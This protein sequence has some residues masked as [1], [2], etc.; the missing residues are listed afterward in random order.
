VYT[1]NIKTLKILFLLYHKI[2]LQYI[3][4]F[5]IAQGSDSNNRVKRQPVPSVSDF[6]LGQVSNYIN[7]YQLDLFPRL[8]A[9]TG[10]FFRLLSH[11]PPCQWPTNDPKINCKSISPAPNGSKE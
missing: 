9:K 5:E 10:E 6:T 2:L 1:F 8:G 4:D 7:C 3:N 11:N